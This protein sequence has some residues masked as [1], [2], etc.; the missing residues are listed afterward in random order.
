M[1]V[2]TAEYRTGD[3]EVLRASRFVS[4]RLVPE[5][6]RMDRASVIRVLLRS[7]LVKKDFLVCLQPSA[8]GD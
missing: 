4:G 3:G 6:W 7:V 1:S 5:R 2:R 8:V